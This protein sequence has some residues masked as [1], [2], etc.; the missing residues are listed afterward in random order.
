[1]A[2]KQTTAALEE[3]R[4]TRELLHR[5]LRSTGKPQEQIDEKTLQKIGENYA[6]EKLKEV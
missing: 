4:M 5:L 6:T 1:M 2:T 3:L